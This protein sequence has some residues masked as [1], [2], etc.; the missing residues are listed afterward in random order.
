MT[1]YLTLSEVLAIHADQVARYGG[2]SGVRDAGLLKAALYRPQ[3]GHYTDG[4]EEAAALWESLAQSRPF[5]AGNQRTAFAATYTFLAINGTRLTASA[6]TTG[7]FIAGLSVAGPFTLE[8]L[9]PWLRRHCQRV[10]SS[11][12][13]EA[14]STPDCTL[15]R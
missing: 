13:D 6:K 11:H 8:N 4:I 3:T 15:L 14:T 1:D 7:A 12:N 2:V 10:M 5:I 9:E